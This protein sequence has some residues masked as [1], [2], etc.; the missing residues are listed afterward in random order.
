[1]DEHV[2]NTFN[3]DA[4]WLIISSY[5]MPVQSTSSNA[6][7]KSSTEVPFEDVEGD[8]MWSVRHPTTG[9]PHF[10]VWIACFADVNDDHG[11]GHPQIHGHRCAQ[12]I[13]GIPLL[14]VAQLARASFTSPPTELENV[15]DLGH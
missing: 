10:A 4:F 14:P 11:Q 12:V 7:T 2:Q 5:F 6:S 3:L 9:M 15:R 1:M 13:C 8:A